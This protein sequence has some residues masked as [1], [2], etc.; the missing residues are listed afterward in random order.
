LRFREAQVL[1]C[2]Y[3]EWQSLSGQVKNQQLPDYKTAYVSAWFKPIQTKRL[4]HSHAS[5]LIS[6]YNA[7]PLLLK[8]V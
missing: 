4:L 8:I 3:D 5:F 6:E 1:K 7:T 2:W